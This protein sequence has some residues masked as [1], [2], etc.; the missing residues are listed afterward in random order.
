MEN[1]RVLLDW[2]ETNEM[3]SWKRAFLHQTAI[4]RVKNGVQL[5]GKTASSVRAKIKIRFFCV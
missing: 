4:V 1:V 3:K 5:N 2:I